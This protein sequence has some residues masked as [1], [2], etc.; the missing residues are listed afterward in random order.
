MGGFF[1]AKYMT[2]IPVNE[3]IETI[4][5]ECSKHGHDVYLYYGNTF[6]KPMP[7]TAEMNASDDLF[8]E[9]TSANFTR[10]NSKAVVLL[11]TNGG[12]IKVAYHLIEHLRKFYNNGITFIVCE[13]AMSAGTF[14]ALSA[15]KLYGCKDAQFSDFTPIHGVKQSSPAELS[16]FVDEFFGAV[17]QFVGNGILGHRSPDDTWAVV[18]KISP[19]FFKI[20]STT[21]HFEINFKTLKE[22]IEEVLEL[23]ENEFGKAMLEAHNKI[24]AIMKADDLDK[25]IKINGKLHI[26]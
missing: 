9:H 12:Q 4:L 5:K 14:A 23:P 24:I 2:P 20:K 6:K 10:S 1:L 15:D 8:I 21:P 25:I 11:H 16:A 18:N 3:Q 13:R 22:E 26:E 19:M 7:A 17:M